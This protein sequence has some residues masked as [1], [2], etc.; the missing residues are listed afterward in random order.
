[1][2]V[3]AADALDLPG[4]TLPAGHRLVSL[5]T[6]PDLRRRLGASNGAAWPPF[7]L[8]DPVAY[9]NWHHLDEDWPE[10]QLL[11][12]DP[13]GAI[14]A[15]SAAAPIAWD[16]TDDGLPASWD[17]QMLRT[18]A[19]LTDGSI[20]S[21]LGAFQVV[22]DPGRQGGGL[23]GVMLT[24]MRVQA[25]G[26]GY[27]AVIACVRPTWKERYPLVPIERYVAW[28]RD[29]GLPFDPWIRLHARMGGRI[30]RAVPRSMTMA[31]TVAEWETWTGMAFPESGDYVVPRAAAPVSIDRDADRGV[32]HDPNVWMVHDLTAAARPDLTAAARPDLTA[33][34]RPDLTVAARPDLRPRP[35]P[36]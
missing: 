33:A 10:H 30:V 26:A 28:V 6:R 21:T 32:Y 16:G 17:E 24:A 1:M 18:V 5:A 13:D 35:A 27:R 23:S 14:A 31:G 36:T 15:T 20:P 19:G 7:M 3:T 9:G 12:L 34:A 4:L 29:D 11:L 25:R 8:E 2:A 22:V